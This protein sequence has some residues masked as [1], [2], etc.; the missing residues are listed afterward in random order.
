MESCPIRK[1]SVIA[2]GIAIGLSPGAANA[3]EEVIVTAQRKEESQQVVPVAVTALSG[4][5]I[6]QQ[7]INNVDDVKFHIPS[8]VFAPVSQKKSASNPTMRGQRQLDTLIAQDSPVGVYFNDV[9]QART[10]GL[11][12]TALYDMK[13]VQAVKG[14]QGTLFGRNTTGGA[15]LFYTNPPTDKF[16]ARLKGGYG[17]FDRVEGEGMLNLPINEVVQVRVA[18]VIAR[19]DGV[20]SNLTRGGEELDDVHYE[21]A[22]FSVRFTPME[23]LTNTFVWDWYNEDSASIGGRLVAAPATGLASAFG[24]FFGLDVQASLRRAI[25]AGQNDFYDVTLNNANSDFFTKIETY[26]FSNTTEIELGGLTIKNIVGAKWI[27]ND[28]SNDIDGSDLALLETRQIQGIEQFSNEFQ[29]LGKSFDDR[30]E[31]ITGAY[32]FREEGSDEALTS[33]FGGGIPTLA[34]P[35]RSLT[36]GDVVNLSYSLFAQGK[37]ALDAI[38]EG[39][40]ITAGLRYTW[41]KREVVWRNSNV[42]PNTLLP[43]DPPGPGLYCR[44]LNSTGAPLSATVSAADCRLPSEESFDEPTYTVSLDYKVTDKVLVYVAHRHGYR[45]GGFNLR[46]LQL[47]EYAPFA[48]EKINDVEIGLKADWEIGGAQARTNLAFYTSDYQDI[49]RLIQIPNPIPGG[50]PN[51]VIINAASATIN[52]FE[53]EGELVPF[54][55]LSIS[56]WLSYTDASYD[57]FTN[58]FSGQDLSANPFAY[59]PEIQIGATVRYVL[60]LD[61]SVGRVAV[62]GNY[63]HTDETAATDTPS[64]FGFVPAYDLFN[65]SLDWDG[66]MGS[67]FDASLYVRNLFDRE[68]VAA[69]FDIQ[70]AFGL[71]THMLGQPREI[72][73]SIGYRWGE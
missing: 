66:V 9:V 29:V 30:L 14:P 37:Y 62:Q 39:L 63:Y 27:D 64:Q 51:S 41:D 4:A 34:V 8:L 6:E 73:V 23:E 10:H 35:V 18:G 36:G 61:Q 13:S 53:F 43:V 55:G 22:R 72:G 52:G 42:N 47:L 71:T 25:A 48:P 20:Q 57:E 17:S 70:P 26:G 44:L 33:V 28:D 38:A 56:G 1:S 46:A 45:S 49:Q 40:S 2:A 60:P 31:W 15:L 19:R 69:V 5:Q 12:G 16:E 24:G 58:P 21:A 3:L 68:Y 67:A 7:G 54:E 50:V 11:I 32:F 65:L 59:V